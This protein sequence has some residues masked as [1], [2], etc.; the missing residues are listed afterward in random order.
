MTNLTLENVE[1]IDNDKEG[2][3]LRCLDCKCEQRIISNAPIKMISVISK[4]FIFEHKECIGRKTN[5]LY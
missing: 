1:F 5:E 2:T 3:F 4:R